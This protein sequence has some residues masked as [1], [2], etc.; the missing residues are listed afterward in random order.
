MTTK[1]ASSAA[2][3]LSKLGAKK[4]GHARAA[5][6]SPEERRASARAASL[7]RWRARPGLTT[8][9]QSVMDKLSAAESGRVQLKIGSG[10][11]GSRRMAAIR[12]LDADGLL[13]LAGTGPGY[14]VVENPKITPR[15]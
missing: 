13:S 3:A 1:A 9:Q 14:A 8:A 5:A 4:G 12:K 2:R 10:P 6:L 11:A 7:S 15:R